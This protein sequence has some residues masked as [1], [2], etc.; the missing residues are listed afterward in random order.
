MGISA[1]SVEPENSF[2][3]WVGGGTGEAMGHGGTVVSGV[4][5]KSALEPN[6]KAFLAQPPLPTPRPAHLKHRAGHHA[7]RSG[8]RHTIS[9]HALSPPCP[10]RQPGSCTLGW[11]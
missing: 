6:T 5:K 11:G 1:C 3:P 9:C 2:K 7:L 10:A 8:E 4:Q